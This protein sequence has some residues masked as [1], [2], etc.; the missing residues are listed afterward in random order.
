M[1]NAAN[2]VG[3]VGTALAFVVP[4]LVLVAV[5][6]MLSFSVMLGANGVTRHVDELTTGYLL[7]SVGAAIACTFGSGVAARALATSGR[8]PLWAAILLTTLAAIVITTCC[9]CGSFLGA[10]TLLGS[11]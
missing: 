6:V 5:W 7:G 8:M 11:F 4:G 2:K 9:G 1:E 10:G 3:P